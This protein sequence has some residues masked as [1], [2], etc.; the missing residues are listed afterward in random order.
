MRMLSLQP[1]WHPLPWMLVGFMQCRAAACRQVAVSE[2]LFACYLP[3]TPHQMGDFTL[4]L[5]AFQ[6]NKMKEKKECP[7]QL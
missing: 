7:Y 3:A 6:G 5:S 2:L 4:F 1:C